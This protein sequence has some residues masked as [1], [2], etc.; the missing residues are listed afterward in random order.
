M[1]S[2]V[3]NFLGEI[4]GTWQLKYLNNHSSTTAQKTVS[5]GRLKLFLSFSRL[6]LRLCP[7]LPNKPESADVSITF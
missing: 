5:W 6:A 4:E 2:V 1:V 3:L 7:L